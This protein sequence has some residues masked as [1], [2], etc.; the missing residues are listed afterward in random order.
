[1]SKV[2]V[3]SRSNCK[4]LTFYHQAEGEPLI[5]RHSCKND[6]LFNIMILCKN[7]LPLLLA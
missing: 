2:K 3:I 4:C 1:M 7:V 6:F 5:E